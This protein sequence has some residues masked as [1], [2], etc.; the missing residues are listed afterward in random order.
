MGVCP[1]SALSCR[2]AQQHAH[3]VLVVL[4]AGEQARDADLLLGQAERACSAGCR[5]SVQQGTCQAGPRGGHR[6]TRGAAAPGAIAGSW[7]ASTPCGTACCAPP[8]GACCACWDGGRACCMHAWLHE[9]AR[10][11]CACS[12]GALPRRQRW[13]D[14]GLPQTQPGARSGRHA[15][16][17]CNS[18]T[19]RNVCR[20]QG[21]SLP[22]CQSSFLSAKLPLAQRA[23]LAL[24]GRSAA[25]GTW[26]GQP[27]WAETGR[28]R[29]QRRRRAECTRACEPWWVFVSGGALWLFQ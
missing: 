24:T 18:R 29:R 26:A 21:A 10:G 20:L 2:T 23:P 12:Q 17:E 3:L 27:L 22:G 5:H 9:R 25:A 16:N 7:R 19:L 8:P 6:V 4:G 11:L 13:F 1:A 28:P 15:R 14:P